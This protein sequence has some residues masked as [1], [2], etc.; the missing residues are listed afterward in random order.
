MGRAGRWQAWGVA[1]AIA[2]AALCLCAPGARAQ[3][4]EPAR[5]AAALAPQVDALE[6][7][8]REARFDEV[9]ERAGELREQLA[10]GGEGEKVRRLRVRVEVAAATADVALE[11]PD[12][13]RAAFR[14]ALAAEPA[15]DLSPDATA[16]K[17][18]RV[19]QS[20]RAEAR[21]PR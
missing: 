1:S 5:D 21:V 19:F 2:C 12:A 9:V 18:L 6:S 17:V 11:R 7:L 16:P 10:T 4:D 8:L 13:A 15:L 3:P 14:R 20:V